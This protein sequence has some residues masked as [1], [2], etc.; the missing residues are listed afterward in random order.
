MI[1]TIREKIQDGRF[2]HLLEELLKA[3]YLEE[4]KFNETL[5]GCPQGGIISPILSNIYLDR[6]DKYVTETLIPAHTKGKGRRKNRAY[7]NLMQRSWRSTDPKEARRLR[8]KA[9]QLPSLDPA[10]PDFRRLRYIRYADDFLL[11]FIGTKEEAEE[12]KRKIGVFLQEELKLDLS[13]TKTLITHAPDERARFLGYEIAVMQN[14]TKH[15]YK[16]RRS[17]NGRIRLG[18]P[19]DV[20][21]AKC[22]RYMKSGKGRRRGEMLDES[23]FSIMSAYQSEYRYRGVLSSG[24]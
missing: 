10:D 1:E 3:G 22:Q 20:L 2:I 18:V 11:G 9:Q 21:E 15:D 8:Q 12:I 6:L 17:I 4:W 14:N 16:H 5:S 13:K 24:P 7:T 23:E 19:E